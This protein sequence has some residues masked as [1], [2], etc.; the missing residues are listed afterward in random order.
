MGKYNKETDR[1]S[2]RDRNKKTP[3]ILEKRTEKERETRQIPTE[4]E[5]QKV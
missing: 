4:I 2:Y 1:E 3:D 5:T